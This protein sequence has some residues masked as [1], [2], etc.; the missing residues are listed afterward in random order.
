M[1]KVLK[2]IKDDQS[3]WS[4]RG[5]GQIDCTFDITPKEYISF[6]EE[7]ANEKTVRGCVNA[8]SNAKRAMD[9]QIDLLLIAFLLDEHAKKKNWNIPK[10]LSVLT[11]LGIVAPRIL[12]KFNRLRNLVEHEF[13]KPDQGTVEDFIDV[14]LLFIESTRLHL[15]DF[16]DDAQIEAEGVYDYWTDVEVNRKDRVVKIRYGDVHHELKP[17]DELFVEF[18]K[19]YVSLAYK[20]L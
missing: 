5:H 17:S 1:E 9:A 10:K 2:L 14:V 7:D 16:L 8:L 19:H 18:M 6:A 3:V 15:V 12:S 13:V 20:Y 4:S 11:E